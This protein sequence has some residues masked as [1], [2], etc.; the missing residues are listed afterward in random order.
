MTH[1]IMRYY[2]HDDIRREDDIQHFRELRMQQDERRRAE[3]EQDNLL[4]SMR[5]WYQ[6]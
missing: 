1:G 5:Y 4:V 3:L 2:E 6:D